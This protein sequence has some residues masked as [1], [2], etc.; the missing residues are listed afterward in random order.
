MAASESVA[1]TNMG[2]E[3]VTDVE[4]GQMVWVDAETRTVRLDRFSEARD[5]RHCFFEW[6]Y[7]AHVTSVMEKQAV[8][9]VRRR[10]GE[11][12]AK[13]EHLQMDED[14]VVVAVPDTAKPIGD[15]FAF[16]LKIPSLEGIVRNRYVG[17]TFIEGE[18]RA[19]KVRR[20]YTLVNSVIRGRRVFLVEDS[21]VRSTTLRDLVERTRAQGG[22]KEVHLRIGSP[23]VIAPCCYGIDMST[24]GELFAPKFIQRYYTQENLETVCKEMARQ[25]GAD[26]LRYLPVSDLSGCVGLPDKHL[27]TACVSGEYPTPAGERIYQHEQQRRDGGCEGRGYDSEVLG[28]GN[29]SLGSA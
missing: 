27:C 9:D 28:E 6:I 14:C 7:F 11:S 23:P 25:L 2:F 20:K 8:Y 5:H 3:N 10:L 13:R 16:N 17:R 12:L 19:A 1:L 22:A 26:S 18:D 21:L 24:L 15:A 29:A 4:P